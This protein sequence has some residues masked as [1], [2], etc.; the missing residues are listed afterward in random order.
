M[1]IIHNINQYENAKMNSAK[2]KPVKS[3]REKNGKIFKKMKKM[4]KKREY[5]KMR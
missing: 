1:R 3:F 4:I 5:E 2:K